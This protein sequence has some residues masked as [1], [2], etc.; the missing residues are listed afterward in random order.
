MKQI[1]NTSLLLCF[2]FFISAQTV[3]KVLI[4][5][6]DGCRPDALQVANT[7]N[8]DALTS[9]SIH[10]M[11]A[12]NDDIT[13]SGPGWSAML[14]G[15]WHNKHGVTDNSFANSQYDQFPHFFNRVEGF[16]SNLHTASICHWGPINDY[17][18]LDEADFKMNVSSD[19]NLRIEAVNYLSNENP[20]VLFLHFDE[21]DHAGH[22][23][24]FSPTVSQY[25]EA[26]E[27]TD[28][29]VGMVISALTARPNYS[30]ENWLILISTD[31]GGNGFSHGGT[32][33]Q[34]EN[35][36]V[37]ASNPQ[38]NPQTIVKDSMVTTIPLPENCLNE[39]I[40]LNFDGNNDYVS[41]PNDGL[42]DFGN[43]QDFTIECR[44][45]TNTPGDVSI[46]GNKDWDSG[47]NPGFVLSFSYPSGPEWKVNIGDGNNRVDINT[48]GEIADGEW[49]TL[50]VSFD[51]D[52]MMTM[53]EDGQELASADISN[54]GDINTN[55]DLRFGADGQGAYA[56]NGAIAEV[57][58]WNSVVNGSTIN[59]WHCNAVELSHPNIGDLIGYWKMNDGSGT[60]TVEDLS[61]NAN[62]GTI[63]EAVWA[64]PDTILV[65]Y[66]YS[67]TPRIT[68][69]AVT[70][71]AH[72]CVP[73]DESW[74]LDGRSLIADCNI[75]SN[76][77][78]LD[79]S[80]VQLSVSPN[81]VGD[82]LRVELSSSPQKPLTIEVFDLG[83]KLLKTQQTSTELSLIQVDQFVP[84]SYFVKVRVR[85]KVLVESFIK[86]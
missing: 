38:L 23:Y 15:V 57:R 11:D 70:A 58:V 64:N 19:E 54:I 34:E 73:I 10:S 68:D 2:T 25:I 24:G 26:I 49:H 37:I 22:A 12:L 69:V 35:I 83:G 42:F 76:D 18:V 72:L 50:S 7:S 36:F 21:V 4:I 82:V 32:T 47:L 77:N 66:D 46:V 75:S 6:I 17:I 1:F 79:E 5:G 14:T 55:F 61:N 30:N 51:R 3:N 86:Q 45:R 28:L 39:T 41:V 40:E 16:D 67:E 31:H 56:Y 9:T 84:G 78:L 27:A 80:K 20:D 65:T 8:I 48:G 60:T 52:G 63:H 29:H 53:Y 43:S 13:I 81:P 62:D 71:L 59:D 85:K 33:I 44:V 74:Q